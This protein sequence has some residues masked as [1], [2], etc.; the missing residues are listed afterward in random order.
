MKSQ[1]FKICQF[2]LGIQQ[3]GIVWSF[4]EN[5]L[6]LCNDPSLIHYEYQE[7]FFFG[8]NN[9]NMLYGNKKQYKLFFNL[10]LG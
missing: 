6:V 4:V 3:Y 10:N 2:V 5:T 1:F 8:E 7:R 9:F